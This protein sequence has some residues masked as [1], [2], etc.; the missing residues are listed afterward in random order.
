MSNKESL[1]KVCVKVIIKECKIEAYAD[2][3]AD[4]NVISKA[5]AEEMNLPLLPT[6]ERTRLYGSKAL[7]CVGFYRGTIRY[8]DSCQ[9]FSVC[10]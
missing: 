7:K 8:G 3:G 2:T 5:K 10:G 4:V 1:P 6:K 9:R